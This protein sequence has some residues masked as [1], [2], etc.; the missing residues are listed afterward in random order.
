ML[1]YYVQWKCPYKEIPG[2][3]EK[4]KISH[5][6]R[7]VTKIFCKH[8]RSGHYQ[9]KVL[10]IIK[11]LKVR[12]LKLLIDKSRRKVIRKLTKIQWRIGG[13]VFI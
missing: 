6:R 5:L 8:F 7:R 10:R 2:I 1:V 9:Q 4:P 11:G 13:G 3:Y 12:G